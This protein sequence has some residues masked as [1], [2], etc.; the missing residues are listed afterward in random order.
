M[1]Y[2]STAAKHREESQR[3]LR[4]AIDHMHQVVIMKC[5][6]ADELQKKHREA[7]ADLYVRVSQ[8]YTDFE[9]EDAT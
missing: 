3:L 4:E 8:A 9:S 2:Q 5:E 7:F 1:S 6:G